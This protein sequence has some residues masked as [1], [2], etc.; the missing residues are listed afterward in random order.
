ME[1]IKKKTSVQTVF[2]IHMAA[3]FIGTLFLFIFVF[4]ILNIGKVYGFMFYANYYE[5]QIEKNIE[6]I[7]N[8]EPF[9]ESSI[10]KGC[11]YALY[12]SNGMLLKTNT[13]PKR[14]SLFW[15]NYQTGITH[16]GAY[17]YKVIQRK[18]E[19]C[20]ISYMV[21]SDF[22]NPNLRKYLPPAEYC[23]Y[24]LFLFSFLG[25]TIGVSSHFSKQYKSKMNHIRQVTDQI[26]KEDSLN[27]EVKSSNWKEIDEV[28]QS[29]DKMK[30]ALSESLESQWKLETERKNQI[31]ALAHDIKTP[32]TVLK[33]NAELLQETNLSKEQMIYQRSI[34]KSISDIEQYVKSLLDIFYLESQ[35]Q[36]NYEE[37][38]IEMFMRELL[39]QIEYLIKKKQINLQI[40]KLNSPKNFRA[41]K[42][43]MLRAIINVLSNSLDYTPQL[44]T[45]MLKVET[46]GESIVFSV[47]DSGRGFTKEEMQSAANLFYQGDKS[48][49]SKLHYG[50]GLAI[51]ASIVQKH[52]G[53][54]SLLNSELMKGARVDIKIPICN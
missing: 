53:T 19:N 23:L 9:D 50:M 3:L 22:K 33:G 32:L 6:T 43:K 4:L 40:T 25:L 24:A 52:G 45:I 13:T 18:N 36:L 34:I 16:K 8:S 51:T 7:Q 41:D 46:D 48:R 47:E 20:I 30:H 39:E 28:L 14:A 29:L 27:F 35:L 1:R 44:G 42:C 5:K 12:N 49:T 10:P 21:A 54:V 11:S 37:I 38:N 31:S 26:R 15:E 17:Y 2:I